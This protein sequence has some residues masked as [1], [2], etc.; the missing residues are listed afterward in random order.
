[1]IEEPES[2]VTHDGLEITPKALAET[3]D[4]QAESVVVPLS[5]DDP[6]LV[7]AL[8]DELL[9]NIAEIPP[10]RSARR[11]D[12]RR[13]RRRLVRKDAGIK[14]LHHPLFKDAKGFPLLTVYGAKEL[15]RRRRAA[16]VARWARRVNRGSRFK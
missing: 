3:L 8:D 6:S 12:K 10:N 16:K 11:S 2:I 13:F 9:K 1:M 7:A 5:M 15:A 4:E 14:R